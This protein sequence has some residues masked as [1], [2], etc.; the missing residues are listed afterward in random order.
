MNTNLMLHGATKLTKGQMKNVK[1]GKHNFHC[2]CSEIEGEWYGDYTPEQALER[3]DMY[4]GEGGG[5]CSM[6]N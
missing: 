4:C 1:G 2:K 6:I 5:R 3:I